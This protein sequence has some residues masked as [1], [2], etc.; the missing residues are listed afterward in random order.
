MKNFPISPLAEMFFAGLPTISPGGLS[1]GRVR[2]QSSTDFFRRVKERWRAGQ[3]LEGEFDGISTDLWLVGY[4]RCLFAAA[5]SL[6]CFTRSFTIRSINFKGMGSF[7]G[8]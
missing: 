8:N 6:S 5:F 4:L 7:S 3:H 1:R 2:P